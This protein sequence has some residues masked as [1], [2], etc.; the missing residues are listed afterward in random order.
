MNKKPGA[1]KDA[2]YKLLRSIR[3]KTYS[4]E[5]KLRIVLACQRGEESI[6]VVCRREGISESLYSNW[7]KEVLE[8][9]K[10]YVP[11][12]I[13]D[14]QKAPSHLEMRPDG[15]V[16]LDLNSWAASP[17][18]NRNILP[19]QINAIAAISSDTGLLI[20]DQV[21]PQTPRPFFITIDTESFYFKRP[22]MITGDGLNGA[23]ATYEILDALD[24]RNLKAVFYVNVYEH[25]QYGDDS[26]ER[27]CKIIH[28]R[29]HE[30]A[31]HCHKSKA[32]NFYNQEIIKYDYDG[33]RRILEYGKD[34]LH[35]WLGVETINFRAG[36]YQHNTDTLAA[37]DDLGFRI[38]SSYLYKRS[39]APAH[40][41]HFVRPYRIGN[42][43]EVPILYL[44]L[45][46]RNGLISDRKFDINSV[47]LPEL[48]DTL[49][50]G[51]PALPVFNYMMH[52]FS[53][54]ARERFSMNH[55]DDTLMM[56][57]PPA[58]SQGL[59]IGVTGL[60]DALWRDFLL[61]L[62]ALS[63]EDSIEVRTM[64]GAIDDLERIADHAPWPEIVP[65]L[66]R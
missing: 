30:V 11:L 8:A 57:S 18:K 48:L 26:I 6:S 7:S 32:L 34:L 14:A 12:D 23:K 42:L 60:R 31:L 22:V 50:R 15:A 3:C 61:F 21:V 17:P 38:D 62:D 37:L 49:N 56:R 4:A 46:Q 63:V 1:F 13:D 59:Y 28:E 53:F 36:G 2:A 45:V 20:T 54:I 35:R 64:S 16:S 43:I 19:A 25:L 52:S 29:G 5:E 65:I 47:N 24:R 10:R 66:Y 58:N 51:A 40:E 33:Q 44:P 39:T 9:G 27:I 55:P 41:G